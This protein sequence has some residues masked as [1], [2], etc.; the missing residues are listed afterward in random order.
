MKALK[1]MRKIQSKTVSQ[2][3]C[4]LLRGPT[5]PWKEIM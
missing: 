2:G 4:D 1:C 3:Y 5:G